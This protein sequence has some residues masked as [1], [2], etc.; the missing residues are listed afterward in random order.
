[1]LRYADV[2]RASIF[3]TG[4]SQS[5]LGIDAV[6]REPYLLDTS[7]LLTLIEEEAGAARVEETL[8]GEA[9]LIPWLAA[10][11]VHYV[12]QQERGIDEAEER[13][14]LIEYLPAELIWEADHAV[15]RQAA[16]FKAEHRISLADAVIAGFAAVRHAVLLHKDPEF[17]VLS[18]QLTL[19]ELPLK[20]RKS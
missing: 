7:A 17:Q 5:E 6:A 8:R 10:L 20:G 15:L 4:F 3:S 13:L 9:C 12:T 14:A 11:E 1:L 18:G 19:E 16:R 2:A